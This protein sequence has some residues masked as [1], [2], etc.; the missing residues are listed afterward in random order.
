[1]HGRVRTKVNYF[2]DLREK[3]CGASNCVQMNSTSASPWPQRADHA[4]VWRLAWPMIVSNLSVPL[5]GLVDAAILGH[6]PDARYLAAVAVATSLFGFLF[7][8]FGFLRMGT[9]GLVA[10]QLGSEDEDAEARARKN[11]AL[12]LLTAQGS[13]LG[14]ALGVLVLLLAPLLFP[15]GLAL[16]GAPA[17]AGAE[18]ARYFEIRIFSAPAVLLTYALTGVL[19][20]LQ[21]TRSVLAITVTTNLINIGLDLLFVPGLGM[22]TEGVAL[23]TLIAEWS[24]CI[25]A[26]RL[27]QQRLAALPAA[28]DWA[29]LRDPDRYRRL[30][31]VNGQLF[32]RTLALLG[33]LA[34]FTAQ[35]ARQGELVLAA[36][37]LL[38]NLLMATSYG[39]DGFAHAVEA[40]SGRHLGARDRGAFRRTLHSAALFSLV[41][42]GTF[43]GLFLIAG[44]EVIA[45]LTDITEVRALAAAYLPWLTALPLVA[46]WCYLFDGLAIGVTETRAMRDSML[47]SALL[48]YLPL[49]WWTRGWGND[50][51]WLALLAFFAARGL[52]L[53]GALW[54]RGVLSAQSDFLGRG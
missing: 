44:P 15:L 37:A 49:W 19:V 11:A 7:W 30:L 18:A 45:L 38:M 17:D 23:A 31:A 39:L 24:G 36:N 28:L 51:L 32:V 9:T 29:A 34:F 1:M 14:L 53:G 33:S 6:L 43:T 12:R 21:D 27:A 50:G 16:M 2:N 8:G 3:W 40:L 4:A 10:Q 46:V 42:A 5:L 20:G 52:T 22:R 26:I 25:V 35:G 13:V 48:V 47:I 41:T 54:H